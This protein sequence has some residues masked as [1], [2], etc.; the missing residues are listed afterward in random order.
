MYILQLSPSQ[1][2]TSLL[3]VVPRMEIRTFRATCPASL[4]ELLHVLGESEII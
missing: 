4:A 1:Y 2:P 3:S